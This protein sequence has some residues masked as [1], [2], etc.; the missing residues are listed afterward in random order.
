MS[1]QLIEAIPHRPEA[2]SFDFQKSLEMLKQALFCHK[3]LIAGTTALTL[4]MV[5]IY[6]SAFPANYQA[7]VVFFAESPADG[8]REE[9]YRNWNVFRSNALADEGVMMTSSLIVAQ[10][11]DDLGLTYDDVYH[12]FMGH[13]G[14]L[15]VQSSIGKAYRKI[16]FSLFPQ[17]QQYTLT[18]EEFERGKTIISFKD[19]VILQPVPDANVAALIARGPSPRIADTV[20]YMADVY[21]AERQKRLVEEAQTAYLA[22][23]QEVNKARARLEDVE[24]RLE[25]H[26]EENSMLLGY[27]KEKL[28]MNS[29]L[30]LQGGIVETEAQLAYIQATLGELNRQLELEDKD[31]VNSRI[32]VNNS[33]RTTLRN[34]IVQ[35]QMN[36]I[37]TKLRYSQDSPEVAEINRQ[38]EGIT[39]LWD[40]EES[41]EVAQSTEM[42]SAIYSS[43][44][45]RKSMLLSELEGVQANLAAKKEADARMA[46]TL[47]SL[48]HKINET[49][50]LE[51]ERSMLSATY[52]GL[53]DRLTM[54]AVSQA[55]I[56]S[57]PSAMRIVD[58]A[59]YPE[60][61]YWPNT[62]LLLATGLILGLIMGILAAII[63]DFIYGRIS[64]YHLSGN[65]SNDTVYAVVSRDSK[66]LSQLYELLPE[67]AEDTQR[68]LIGKI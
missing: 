6:M 30:E 53:S 47:R 66:F 24:S 37:Q 35:L 44:E 31:V 28:Q 57:A 43:L 58:Y 50:Q 38:I 15:W 63:I 49:Q 65:S 22:L 3:L 55:T 10:V 51:R 2:D 48:P 11:V 21:L 12:T 56:A 8:A 26:Y 18:P 13:V 20:N 29:W 64:R 59:E 36:L 9:F 54:A 40:E 23:E 33:A 7:Q 67:P 14:H 19:G 4:F 60:R 52:T 42:V 68:K 46:E 1:N 41:Q 25:T 61:P 34:Q 27:E 5:I 45:S 39:K 62:K 17:P 32:L 16:K